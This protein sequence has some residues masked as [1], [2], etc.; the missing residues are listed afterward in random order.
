MNPN[1]D[2][3]PLHHHNMRKQTDNVQLENI[4]KN[5]VSK[6]QEHAIRWCE[7]YHVEISSTR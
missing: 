7:R 3:L 2:V 6:Q 4:L 1:E 5:I